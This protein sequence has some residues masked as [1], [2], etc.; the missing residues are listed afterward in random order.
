MGGNVYI[1]PRADGGLQQ[2]M[3]IYA[4]DASVQQFEI[5]DPILRRTFARKVFITLVVS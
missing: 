5:P 3:P 4:I 1:E 2:T